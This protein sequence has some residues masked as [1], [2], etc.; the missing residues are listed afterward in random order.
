MHIQTLPPG[1]KALRGMWVYAIKADSTYKAR[2]VVKG[3]AQRLGRD[4]TKTFSPVARSASLWLLAALA[5]LRGL[6]IYAVD[7]TAVFLH[8]P[9][10]EEISMVP[11]DGWTGSSGGSSGYLRLVRSLHGLKQAG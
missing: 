9:L 7:F 1:H 11:P 2:L 3:C 4:Y 8:G 10:E 6:V 5:A